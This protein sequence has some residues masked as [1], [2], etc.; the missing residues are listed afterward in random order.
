MDADN[1]TGSCSSEHGLQ[2]QEQE[3]DYDFADQSEMDAFNRRNFEIAQAAFE[4]I[5]EDFEQVKPADISLRALITVKDDTDIDDETG[6]GAVRMDSL[7]HRVLQQ[8]QI[9]NLYGIDWSKTKTIT[10]DKPNVS[11]TFVYGINPVIIREVQKH[12]IGMFL[13]GNDSAGVYRE[14][15]S[16]DDR[17][18]IA[19]MKEFKFPEFTVNKFI[20]CLNDPTMPP[21]VVVRNTIA[22]VLDHTFASL[23]KG[24][25][26][27]KAA[28]SQQQQ[29]QQQRSDAMDTGESS[30]SSA[31][32]NGNGED[33]ENGDWVAYEQQERAKNEYMMDNMSKPLHN[34][35]KCAENMFN[36]AGIVLTRDNCMDLLD[37]HIASTG[38]C[39]M[40]ATR[41]DRAKA[42]KCLGLLAQMHW[43]VFGDD[44]DSKRVR[45]R[46]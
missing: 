41:M 6:I 31:S 44:D 39:L 21:S 33:V 23:V 35:I 27:L 38:R 4:R 5:P 8:M 25:D 7:T 18:L 17:E 34:R 43:I 37:T 36:E 40:Y 9:M 15:H 26:A 20:E 1:D 16:Y 28:Q 10:V 11:G 14:I 2:L 13:V 30:S 42:E 12:M 29:Q 3:Q 19:L 32:E 22:A 46:K 45:T 24:P